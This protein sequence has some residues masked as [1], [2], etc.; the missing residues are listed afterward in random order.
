MLARSTRCSRRRFGEQARRG[1]ARERLE[2][3]RAR[4]GE[5]IEHGAA[6]DSGPSRG[7]APRGR[8][9]TSVARPARAASP[10]GV[11]R[12]RR[13]RSSRPPDP[14]D[15][16]AEALAR[17]PASTGSNGPARRGSA[18][19]RASARRA[20]RWRERLAWRRSVAPDWRRPRARPRR[21]CAGRA[22]RARSR[23]RA[24]ERL[25]GGA[26]QSSLGS[27]DSN[28]KQYDWSLPAPDAAAQLVQLREPEAI[29][30]LDH[31]RGR[32][33]DVDADLDH[34]GRH[35][36][37]DLGRRERAHRRRPLRPPSDGRA[38]APRG[39]A[40]ARTSSACSSSAA[41]ACTSLGALHER[42]HT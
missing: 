20:R 23:S 27:G 22:R 30:V 21:A 35:E 17:G 1:P 25:R 32:V 3:E 18:R 14:L 28:R 29:G 15:E 4:A 36:H 16:R 8:V 42:A 26:A 31:H 13:R 39:A 41:R 12:A 11:R 38:R 34:G 6:V 5:E 9:R 19:R 7:T 37:V 10:G 40:R 2:A 24:R 33:R